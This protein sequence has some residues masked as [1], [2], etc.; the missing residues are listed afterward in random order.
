[1]S[2]EDL[3]IYITALIDR[4]IAVRLKKALPCEGHVNSFF[5]FI[6][7]LLFS[8]NPDSGVAGHAST[9]MARP[10]VTARTNSEDLY[11]LFIK[12]T[13]TTGGNND[14]GINSENRPGS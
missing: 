11:A 1:M 9:S 8:H 6:R 12:G 3:I 2:T 7:S 14:I 4:S 10:S 5:T 13:G